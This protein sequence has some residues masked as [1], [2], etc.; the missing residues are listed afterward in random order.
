MINATPLSE[1]P[2]LLISH[3]VTLA[4][5]HFAWL[6]DRRTASGVSQESMG[7]NLGDV[8]AYSSDSDSDHTPREEAKVITK[9]KSVSRP[10]TR[11]MRACVF[12]ASVYF[13]HGHI[14]W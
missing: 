11:H 7:A 6:H 4:A 1:L 3:G 9:P 14:I 10:L 13:C 8:D 2:S 12:C 5:P